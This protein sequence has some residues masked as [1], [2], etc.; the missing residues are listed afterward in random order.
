[1]FINALYAKPSALIGIH[2]W[3]TTATSHKYEGVI[4]CIFKYG[5]LLSAASCIGTQIDLLGNAS[6]VGSTRALLLR[7][8]PSVRNR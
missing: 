8:C 3:A 1:M 4:K 6:S 2:L 7:P 5:N